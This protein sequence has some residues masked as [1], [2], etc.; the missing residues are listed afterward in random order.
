MFLLSLF[1]Y[2]ESSLSV[3]FQIFIFF[4]KKSPLIFLPLKIET[5]KERGKRERQRKRK[6]DREEERHL[7]NWRNWRNWRNYKK[8]KREK[9]K[10]KRE[11]RRELAHCARSPLFFYPLCYIFRSVKPVNLHFEPILSPP[12]QKVLILWCFYPY[13]QEKFANTILAWVDSL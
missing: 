8:Y 6:R 4:W 7:K 11:K 9:R 10:E 2:S 1:C 12:F 13:K 5:Y 3:C